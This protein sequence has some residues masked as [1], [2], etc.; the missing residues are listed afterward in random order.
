MKTRLT[1]AVALIAGLLAVCTPIFAHHGNAA[2]D[3]NKVVV[4]K[5]AKIT[6]VLWANPHVLIFFDVKDKSG[7]VAHWVAEAGSP[8]A[9]FPQGWTSGTLQPGDVITARLFQAKS[10]GTVGR[11]G[12]LTLA[13]G[14]V[15]TAFGGIDHP[16]GIGTRVDNCDQKSVEGGSGSLACVGKAKAKPSK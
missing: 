10:G 1:T 5:D 2:Y 3:M 13:S 16:Y 11:M 15:L 9:D 4:L 7:D 14:R 8:S 6:K 12:T